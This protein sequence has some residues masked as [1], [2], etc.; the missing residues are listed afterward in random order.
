[1]LVPLLE[2]LELGYDVVY[3][4]LDVALVHDPIP[5][6]V[7]GKADISLSIEMKT[8]ICPS[9]I[10]TAYWADWKRNEPNTGDYITAR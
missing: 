9:V 1:M 2:I 6:L 10:E 3:I 7:R 4:D 5:S 8:C